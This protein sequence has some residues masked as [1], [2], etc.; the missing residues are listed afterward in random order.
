[1]SVRWGNRTQGRAG[2]VAALTLL[3]ALTLPA[4]GRAAEPPSVQQRLA[5]EYSPILEIRKQTDPPCQTSTEQ[6]QPT[7]VDTVLG[8]PTVTLTHEDPTAR[9][10][11]RSSKAPTAADIAGLGDDYYLDLEGEPARRHLRLRARLRQAGRRK[12][13]R[14]RSPTPT[15]PANRTTPA[16]PSSTGS[17]GTSTSSTT[18]TRATG[19]GC[20]SASKSDTPTAA[21]DEEPNEVIVFQHAGGERADWDD[22]KVQ[23]EG[24][25]PIVY[26]AAG[27]HATFYDSA[28]YVQNGQHGSGARLRQHHRAAARAAA[29]AGPAAGDRAGERPLRSGS[30]T[31]AAG[32]EREKGF[33]NGPT[34][35]ADEDGLAGTVRLDGRAAH[36]QPAAARRLGRRRRR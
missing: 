32:A 4:S 17:S 30:A 2:V 34:G 9:G 26:P 7:S 23:K 24:T 10:W 11:R 16:S 19:R 29:A 1:M 27:S 31:T 33:N 13:R 6:Y 14:R 25:H 21:L 20:S 18:S 15:S 35:P 12:A 22:A 8:N 28:V 5:T 36:D 3:L